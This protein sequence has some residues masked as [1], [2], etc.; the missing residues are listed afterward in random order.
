MNVPAD[1]EM[2]AVYGMNKDQNCIDCGNRNGAYCVLTTMR[3][4][5]SDYG[6]ACKRFIK[7]SKHKFIVK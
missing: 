1:D 2:R 5:C 6:F 3:R 7:S 4:K